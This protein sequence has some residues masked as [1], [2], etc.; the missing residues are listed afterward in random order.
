M[1][2]KLPEDKRIKLRK[3]VGINKKHEEMFVHMND[4]TGLLNIENI[5]PHLKEVALEYNRLFKELYPDY[6]NLEADQ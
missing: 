6:K 2:I 4:D 1:M 5:E 3:M